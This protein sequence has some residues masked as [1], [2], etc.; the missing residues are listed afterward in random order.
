[1]VAIAHLCLPCQLI[2]TVTAAIDMNNALNYATWEM[3]DTSFLN[4]TF[5][6]SNK[7]THTLPYVCVCVHSIYHRGRGKR[8]EEEEEKSNFY[9]LHTVSG[10]VVGR[11]FFRARGWCN[12]R[13]TR[14]GR[15]CNVSSPVSCFF[16][17]LTEEGE[18][19]SWPLSFLIAKGGG[20]HIQNGIKSPCRTCES[21]VM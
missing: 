3:D 13:T 18:K 15:K 11:F 16:S 8:E 5:N 20:N 21:L 6:I 19:K 1:M 2:S 12:G 4:Y 7:C 10:V 9:T 17:L 14:T